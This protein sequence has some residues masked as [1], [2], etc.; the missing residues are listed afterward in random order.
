MGTIDAFEKE[1]GMQPDLVKNFVPQKMLG[2]KKQ[3]RSIF[4]GTGDSFASSLLAQAFSMHGARAHDPLDLIKNRRLLS[5]RDLYL[6][7]ISGNTISNIRLAKIHG[8]AVAITSQ[9]KSRLAEECGRAIHLKFCST[10]VQTA[11]SS[12]FLSSALTC[13]SLVSKVKVG[14]ASRILQEARRTAKGIRLHG[15]VFVLGNLQTFP[16]AMFCAAKLYEVLGA[17]AHYE[18][19]EQFSHMGL[20]SARRGDTVLLFEESSP[21]SEN[22]VKALR[23]CGLAVKRVGLERGSQLDKVV[24]LIFV[25]ELVA[26][27][28]ARRKKLGECF[29]IEENGLRK[30]SSSMIY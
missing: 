7:S 30:A 6:V 8:R 2:P 11:G 13:I 18:R 21:H 12:S 22:L 28:S 5:G 19:I 3:A 16:V 27:Y 10:G 29:F 20:F 24:F 9:P 23:G 26:L 1:I 15:K 14:N 25:S 17:D 4:C